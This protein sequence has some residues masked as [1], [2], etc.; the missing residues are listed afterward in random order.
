MV[1]ATIKNTGSKCK[2]CITRQFGH[3]EGITVRSRFA[4]AQT[5]AA[6]TAREF[7]CQSRN[8]VHLT[9][10]SGNDFT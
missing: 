3:D 5:K 10:L 4:A 8:H 6:Q 1:F 7:G 2:V 9:V